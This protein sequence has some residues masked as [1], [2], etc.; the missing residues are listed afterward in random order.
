MHFDYGQYVHIC[1]S[2]IVATSLKH[3]HVAVV[4]DVFQLYVSIVIG[5]IKLVPPSPRTSIEMEV[6][7][8]AIGTPIMVLDHLYRVGLVDSKAVVLVTVIVCAAK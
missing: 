8:S 7:R 3:D 1:K 4:G 2:C 5:P 6:W